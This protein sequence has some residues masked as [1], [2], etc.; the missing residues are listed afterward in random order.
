M[1]MGVCKNKKEG[2][3]EMQKG[4]MFLKNKRSSFSPYLSKCCVHAYIWKH[5]T[6]FVNCQKVLGLASQGNTRLLQGSV[7][8][9]K[10][11]KKKQIHTYTIQAGYVVTNCQIERER[12]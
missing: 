7:F 11:K 1:C 8:F 6:L 5:I 9:C 12:H 3:R 10:N 2:E 4:T